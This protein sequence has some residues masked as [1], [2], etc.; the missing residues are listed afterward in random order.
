MKKW[1]PN[2]LG[3]W[4]VEEPAGN[5]GLC[6]FEACAFPPSSYPRSSKSEG[7]RDSIF[8]KALFIITFCTFWGYHLT[9]C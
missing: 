7:R 4:V 2:T 3:A 8:Q 9:F 5:S 6:D 1:G